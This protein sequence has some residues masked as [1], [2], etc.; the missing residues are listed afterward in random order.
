MEGIVGI[1][2]SHRP[3]TPRHI[4]PLVWEGCFVRGHGGHGCAWRSLVA[5]KLA[6]RDPHAVG[7]LQSCLP[8]SRGPAA[9][10]ITAA[11]YPWPQPTSNI[12]RACVN[13]ATTDHRGACNGSLGYM[14]QP[15]PCLRRCWFD[16]RYRS[17]WVSARPP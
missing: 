15:R 14:S 13:D 10:A 5:R 16:N 7:S 3:E 4:G 8:G 17:R 2:A 1:H 12:R 9:E 6:R 11:V